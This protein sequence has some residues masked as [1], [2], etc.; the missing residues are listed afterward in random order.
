MYPIFDWLGGTTETHRWVLVALIVMIIAEHL[1]I[2][3]SI[4]ALRDS[5][6]LLREWNDMQDSIAEGD[7]RSAVSDGVDQS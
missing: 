6:N 4:K 3:L 1:M 2:N 7:S 5:T